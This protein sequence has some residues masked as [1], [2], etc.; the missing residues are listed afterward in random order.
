M[1]SLIWKINQHNRKAVL[2]MISFLFAIND[3][4][5]Q[6]PYLTLQM[7]RR[8]G[9]NYVQLV[10]VLSYLIGPLSLL[11]NNDKA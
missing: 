1:G 2:R 8:W 11:T 10:I 3:C 5:K 7:G 6:L 9:G 4:R